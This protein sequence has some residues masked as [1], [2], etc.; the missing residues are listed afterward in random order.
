ML[1]TRARYQHSSAIAICAGQAST[2]VAVLARLAPLVHTAPSLRRLVQRARWKPTA[3]TAH[4][5]ALLAAPR[6]TTKRLGAPPAWPAPRGPTK[7]ALVL[8]AALFV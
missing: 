3:Y 7:R 4:L 2:A 1:S 6:A 8:Q 5:L